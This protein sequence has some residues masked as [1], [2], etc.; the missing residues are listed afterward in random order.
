MTQW[1]STQSSFDPS[2]SAMISEEEVKE[3]K[4]KARVMRSCS[5]DSHIH[6]G[7]GGKKKSFPFYSLGQ[8]FS[9]FWAKP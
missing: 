6:E 8:K 1:K 2:I 9:S 4:K 7:G 5:Q 3:R